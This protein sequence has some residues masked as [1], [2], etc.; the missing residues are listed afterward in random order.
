MS[1]AAIETRDSKV[2]RIGTLELHF[3]VDET[4]DPASIVMFEFVVPPNARCLRR[5]IIAR[6]MKWFMA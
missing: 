6:W 4:Q 5:T 3:L 2:V 1:G